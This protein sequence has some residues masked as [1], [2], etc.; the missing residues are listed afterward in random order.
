M[1]NLILALGRKGS[2]KTTLQHAVV[3]RATDRSQNTRFIVWDPVYEWRSRRNVEVYQPHNTQFDDVAKRALEVGDV[4]LVVD[5]ID[6]QVPN[7]AGGLVPGSHIYQIVH[8]GRHYRTALFGAA[9]RTARIHRDL[10]ALSDVIFLFRHTEPRD[11]AYLAELFGSGV[12]LAARHLQP[13]Q[14]F[15]LDL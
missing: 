15:R 2:G 10:T 14:F 8:C 13:R 3:R 11:L 5:E 4:T 9:R 12:A 6:F 1:S 7:H